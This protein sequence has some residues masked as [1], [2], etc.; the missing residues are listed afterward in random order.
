VGVGLP[1]S[2]RSLVDRNRIRLSFLVR[3]GSKAYGL[4][5]EDSDDDY[6]GVF[7]PRLRDLLS[8]AGLPSDT[9]AGND[10][11][12][13]LHEIGKFCGLAL[14]GNPAI[15]ETLWNPDV[16]SCDRWGRELIASRSKCLHRGSLAVYASYAEAQ[17]KKMVRGG[18]LHARG[19]VYNGKFGLHLI[20][21]LHAGLALAAT[22]QVMVRVPAELALTLRRIRSGE[23]GMDAVVEMSGPLLEELG[24]KSEANDLPP[25]PDR[26]AF[27]DLVVRARLS[28]A[29]A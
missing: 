3:A 29:D 19:G 5:V 16:V 2:I 22:G 4:E 15:L 23:I 8:I 12:F 1:E 24:R 18:G 17:L 27:E 26:A 25:Q 9:H 28:T 21:L 11:D 14:K 10:P 20:R 6:L 13:T 7:V